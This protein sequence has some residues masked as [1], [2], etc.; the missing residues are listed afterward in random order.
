MPPKPSLV[1]CRSS[2]PV[3]SQVA[4]RIGASIDVLQE[5]ANGDYM[6]IGY[7]GNNIDILWGFQVLRFVKYLNEFCALSKI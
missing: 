6:K 1:G 4:D 3:A 7:V 2:V 5:I